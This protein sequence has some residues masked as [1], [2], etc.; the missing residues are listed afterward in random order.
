MSENIPSKVRQTFDRLQEARPEYIELKEINDRYYV[1]S[2][3]SEWDS[4][5]QKPKKQTAYLGA[6]SLEGEFTPKQLSQSVETTDRE[7]FEYGNGQLAASLLEDVRNLLPEYTPHSEELIAMAIIQALD[8][9]PLR[10]HASRWEKLAISR[11]RSVRLSPKHLSTVLEE[12]GQAVEWWHEVFSALIG[13]D[14]LLLYDLTTVFSYSQQ[15]SLAEKGYNAQGKYLDQIGVV[16]AFSQSQ[17]LP[18]GV[19]VYWGSLKDISTIED[20]LDRLPE[21]DLGF[22]LDRG[23][24]SEPLLED[25]RTEDISYVAPIRK[26]SRLFDTRWVRWRDPFVYRER[27]LRWGRRHTDHGTL[28]LFEDP[29]LRGEQE[30]ALLRKVEEGRLDQAAYEEKKERA[31]VIG[32]VSDLDREGPAIFDLYKGRQDIEVAFD[33]M[34]NT[35]DADTTYLQTDDA[36]RGYF[37]VTL[38]ALRIYFGILRRLRE[39]DLTGT[40]SVKEVLFELSK[41][42]LIVES[43]DEKY[44]AEVPKQAREIAALFPESLPMG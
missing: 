17:E 39:R 29:E 27:A 1:Y 12:T 4:T 21:R 25:F 44:F 36:V 32:L 14:D 15:I 28:Y 20:F 7:I 34:K 23:F 38:L 41:I 30:A 3:T 18:A 6:I 26:N 9:Q 8:P 42:Q 40:L 16:L 43:D 2:A 22:I 24:W 11:N 5:A 35:L 31:G 10:L 37:F 19:E 13:E 33:A